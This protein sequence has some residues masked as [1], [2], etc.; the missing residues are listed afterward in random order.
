MLSVPD[1][2]LLQVT[3]L[4]VQYHV[5]YKTNGPVKP[6]LWDTAT[7]AIPEFRAHRL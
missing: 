4:S 7:Q 3:A 6:L 5:M 2:L 1:V